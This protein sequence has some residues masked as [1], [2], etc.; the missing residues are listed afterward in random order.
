[1]NQRIITS[2]QRRT[3]SWP[4]SPSQDRDSATASCRICSDTCSGTRLGSLEPPPSPLALYVLAASH[5]CLPA[6]TPCIPQNSPPRHPARDLA[7]D[8][9]FQRDRKSTRLNSS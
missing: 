8:S 1:M 9:I 4:A 3:R 5:L 6:H 7:V 2:R